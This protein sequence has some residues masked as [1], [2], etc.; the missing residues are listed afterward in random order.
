MIEGVELME[1]HI[2]TYDDVDAVSLVRDISMLIVDTTV[3]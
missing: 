3:N 2:K 1:E